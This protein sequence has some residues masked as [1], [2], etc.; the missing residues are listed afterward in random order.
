MIYGFNE[1]HVS[2]LSS[3]QVI[4]Q[5][6]AI[7]ADIYQKT[8]ASDKISGNRLRVD[9]SFDFPEELPRPRTALLLRPVDKKG[10]ETWFHLSPEDTGREHGPFP[11]G[12][13]E[14]SMIAPAF[15][16]EPVSIPIRIEE[17]TVPKVKF[18]MKPVG[19]LRGYVVKNERNIQAGKD[20]QPDTE[21]QIQS[22]TL[23]GSG[24]DRTLIPLQEEDISY[25]EHYPEHYFS[26]TDFT[27]EGTFF[28]FGLPA[29]KYELTINAKG[30]EQYSEK[31]NVKIGQ[32]Q[33]TITI[34]LVK[35]I[36][37]PP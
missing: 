26:E 15:A 9:F 28:F 20:R 21:V 33:N 4:S 30:Y 31:C 10:D 8:K 14:V 5:Y 35:D 18:S 6:N 2:I 29:G 27:S 7:L 12:N 3:K 1:D 25:S 24:I 16:P 22:I 37:D 17:G 32:Y 34:E 19:Y 23:R 11:S 13:Y 36:V